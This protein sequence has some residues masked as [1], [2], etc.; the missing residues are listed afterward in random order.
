[1]RLYYVYKHN[2]Q[3]HLEELRYFGCGIHIDVKRD[4][5]ANRYTVHVLLFRRRVSCR[6]SI[7]HE[8]LVEAIRLWGFGQRLARFTECHTSPEEKAIWV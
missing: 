7:S 3:Y 2:D 5:S 6:A 1:M 4:A 8:F